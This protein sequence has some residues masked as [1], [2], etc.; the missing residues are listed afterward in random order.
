MLAG[1]DA[2]LMFLR[3]N[4]ITNWG[5]FCPCC[6][7]GENFALVS[8][9]NVV[10]CDVSLIYCLLLAKSPMGQSAL[11]LHSTVILVLILEIASACCEF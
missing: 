1:F 7:L 9:F 5:K 4:L 10:C 3:I 2:V 11:I 6:C 8:D